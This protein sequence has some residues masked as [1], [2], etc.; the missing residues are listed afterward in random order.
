MPPTS[1]GFQFHFRSQVKCMYKIHCKKVARKN[2]QHTI[3]EFKKDVTPAMLYLY[4]SQIRPTMMYYCQI[5]AG[6]AQSFLSSQHIAQNRLH[7]PVWDN[8]F[9]SATF[10][11][12]LKPFL[13]NGVS[14]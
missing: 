3:S 13:S 4:Q 7:D 5:S 2:G 6:V 11:E 9:H 1:F 12:F 10:V 14:L 8:I